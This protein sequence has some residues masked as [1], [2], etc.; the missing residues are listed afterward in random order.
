M[1]MKNI[2]EFIRTKINS[3]VKKNT[4][5]EDQYAKA[6]EQVI[7]QITRL[8]T[9]H[10]KS[11]SEEKR[12]RQYAKDKQA[13]ARRKDNEIRMLMNQNVPVETHVKLAILY[14]RT[15]DALNAKA[16]ELEKMRDE[17]KLAV[18]ELDNSRLDLAAKLEFIRETRNAEALGISCSEDVIELAGLTKVD[19]NDVMMRI[20]TFNGDKQTAVTISEIENYIN[21][22]K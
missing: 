20:E 13:E 4:S 10:V 6:A 19:V 14:R 15:A 12:L 2:A 7:S 8:E 16:D 22:L 9:A 5:I 21:G 11:V 18:V 1:S 17:I 3:F